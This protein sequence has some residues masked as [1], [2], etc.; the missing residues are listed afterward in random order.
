MKNPTSSIPTLLGPNGL[1]AIGIKEK[2]NLLRTIAF[3]KAKEANLE[4]IRDFYYPPPI[5]S[6]LDL[7]N[8]E[9]LGVGLKTLKDSA[10]GPDGIP[11]RVIHLVLR[12]RIHLLQPLLEKCLSLGYHPQAF[13]T[14]QTVFLQKPKKEDYTS[15]NAYRPIALLNTLG[16]LLESIVATRLRSISEENSLLPNS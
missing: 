10:P 16:K 11:N 15:P 12:E 7:P 1:E 13:H 3:S 6:D 4:D 14:A 5:E 8:D 9:I 2:A